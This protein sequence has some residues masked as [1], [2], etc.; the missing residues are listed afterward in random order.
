MLDGPR[1]GLMNHRVRGER[2]QRG[3]PNRWNLKSFDLI[4]KKSIFLSDAVWPEIR[5]RL[6]TERSP[7][8]QGRPSAAVVR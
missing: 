6:R 1:F 3:C 4:R 8:M 5:D 7:E 2:R